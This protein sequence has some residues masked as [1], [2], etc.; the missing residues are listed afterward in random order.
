MW[1]ELFLLTH[2]NE[3]VSSNMWFLWY[4]ST[5]TYYVILNDII[6]NENK[7][8]FSNEISC[9]HIM[10][11]NNYKNTMKKY[12]AVWAQNLTHKVN[13]LSDEWFLIF[14]L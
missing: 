11:D 1:N 9:S 12:E 8:L 7:L 3:S 6:Y 4:H 10:A 2:R 13:F 14:P 5:W